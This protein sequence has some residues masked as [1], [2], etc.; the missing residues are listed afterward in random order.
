MG[1]VSTTALATRQKWG[2]ALGVRVAVALTG[3]LMLAVG[4]WA[5]FRP[6]VEWDVVIGPVWTPHL[7]GGALL[8]GGAAL[9][10]AF[11]RSLAGGRSGESRAWRTLLA[12]GA[13]ALVVIGALCFGVTTVLGCWFWADRVALVP[14]HGGTK[15]YVLREETG[16][17]DGRTARIGDREGLIVRWGAPRSA[18]V[19]FAGTE[20][21]VTSV[22]R[23]DGR[24]VVEFAAGALRGS[25][26]L[27]R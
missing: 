25:A 12:D 21:A 26:P 24:T 27:A 6:V 14:V 18:D 19:S 5:V 17:V 8:G 20:P 7:A 3:C 23:E 22:R 16:F 13:S 2:A 1:V 10:V 9:T 15:T 4:L 11:L